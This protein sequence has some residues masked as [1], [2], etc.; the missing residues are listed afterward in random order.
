MTGRA[1]SAVRVAVAGVALR[2]E[3]RVLSVRVATAFGVP[4]QCVITLHD[5]AGYPDWPEPVS[6][7]APFSVDVV[8]ED[9][10]LFAGEV[11]AAE[12]VRAADGTM[13]VRIR[14]YDLLHRLRRRQTLRVWESVTAAAL[15]E[16]LTAGLGL[17]VEASPAGSSRSGALER[18]VQHRQSDFDLL[19]EVAARVGQLVVLDG[20]TLRLVSLDGYGDAIPLRCGDS[21]VEA[22]VEANLDRATGSVTALGWNATDAEPVHAQ[23]GGG[24]T[25]RRIPLEVAADGAVSL[26]E[27]PAVSADDANALAQLALETRAAQTVVLRGVAEGDARLRPGVRVAV[28]GMAKSIDGRYVLSN[29]V[30]V[31]DGA[32]YRTTV[33]TEPPPLA[34][35][36]RGAA[37]TLGRVTSVDDP[38]GRGRVR[39]ALPALGDLDAG[40]LGVVCPGAG[41]GKGLVALPDVDDTVAVALP[42]ADPTTGLVLGSLYGTVRPPDPGISGDAVRRWSLRTADGQSIV[43]DDDAHLL[44][45]ENHDGSHLELAPDA[46]R[47]QAKTDLVI[48]AAGHAITIRAS[49]VEFEHAS[50]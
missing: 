5:A 33:S 26:L 2:P 25:G 24:Y 10:T 48:D 14:G 23:A 4:A 46:V 15:A 45:L 47:I 12:L 29:V 36:E 43:L 42:H 17:T 20:R 37:I 19:V 3:V 6:L 1:V 41:R 49:S 30:Q 9:T 27:Q 7:G 21:L 16:E 8:G 44:R 50:L 31:V 39:V 34:D 22:V 32:G 11:T 38:L 28:S 18:V 35:P 40:W 13:T